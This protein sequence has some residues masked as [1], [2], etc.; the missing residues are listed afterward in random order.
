VDK[1]NI[2]NDLDYVPAQD[3]TDDKVLD[4]RQGKALK[5]LIDGMDTAYKAADTALDGR[6]TTAEGAIAT[7]NGNASTEGS[8]LNTVNTRIADVVAEA[9]EAFDTL[10]E[11]ADWIGTH[12]TSA[13]EMQQDIADNADAIEAL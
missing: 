2:Y 11:I 10:K 1:T 6:L 3:A 12:S 13:L 7:L 9:P 8:V 5:D 4:A